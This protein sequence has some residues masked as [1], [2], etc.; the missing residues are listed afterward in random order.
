VFLCQLWITERHMATSADSAL[1]A[2]LSSHEPLWGLGW[3]GVGMFGICTNQLSHL[4]LL[5]SAYLFVCLCWYST[6]ELVCC[7][8]VKVY[9]LHEIEGNKRM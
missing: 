5:V 4:K 6:E 9:I 2:T 7:I 1:E 8:S 3:E